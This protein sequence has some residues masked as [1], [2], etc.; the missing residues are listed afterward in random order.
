MDP[1]RFLIGGVVALLVLFGIFGAVNSSAKQDAY[2]QGYLMGR[3]SAS[4]EGATGPVA[5]FMVPGYGYPGG[6]GGPRFGGNPFGFIFPLLFFGLVL[7]GL[8]R[9]FRFAA[10][11]RWGGPRGYGPGGPWGGP[12]GWHGQPQPPAGGGG[13]G[14]PQPGWGPWGWQGQTPPGWGQAPGAAPK[15]DDPAA[16]DRPRN[17][18]YV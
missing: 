10:W 2:M 18:S 8:S 9:L 6:F 14:Q 16:E 15:S 17:A 3:L 12:H 13:E 5:P 4:G 7:F 1:R 11:R